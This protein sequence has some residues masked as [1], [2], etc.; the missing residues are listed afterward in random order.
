[1]AHNIV[2][3]SDYETCLKEFGTIR[4]LFKHC[5]AMLDPEK[6]SEHYCA[7]AH[8]MADLFIDDNISELNWTCDENTIFN[9]ELSKDTLSFENEKEQTSDDM[10]QN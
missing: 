5:L 8:M 9:S 3:S 1:M 6:F 2:L 7:A 10:D 4:T